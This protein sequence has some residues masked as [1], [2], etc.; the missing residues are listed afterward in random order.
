MDWLAGVLFTAPCGN[1]L[2]SDPPAEAIPQVSPL[3][4]VWALRL[5]RPVESH[6]ITQSLVS[7]G[8]TLLTAG[9]LSPADPLP[10][11]FHSEPWSSFRP[12]LQPA[13]STGK[14]PCGTT[15]SAQAPNVCTERTDT[16]GWCLGPVGLP[17]PPF[18]DSDGEGP[19]EDSVMFGLQGEW[20]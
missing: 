17:N 13:W 18:H 9:M 11:D 12:R 1:Q 10:G 19:V 16:V 6:Q 4:P 8:L 3:S 20:S 14:S 15:W 5:R 7:L 2:V